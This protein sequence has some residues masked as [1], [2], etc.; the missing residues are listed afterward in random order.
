MTAALV[1]LGIGSG[2]VFAPAAAQSVVVQVVDSAGMAIPFALV[3]VNAVNGRVA[4]SAGMLRL[5]N[6]RGDTLRIHA[7]RIGYAPFNGRVG[8]SANDGVFRVVLARMTRELEAA[9]VTAERSTPLARNGFYDRMQRVQKGAIVGEF[10]TPEELDQRKPMQISHVLQGRRY[11]HVQREGMRGR[12][13]VGGRGQCPM[14][15]LLDGH[16]MNNVLAPNQG[17]NEGRRMGGG[18]QG[19]DLT[20]SIDE[21]VEGGS[22][23]AVE[24]YPSTANAPAELIPLTGGGSCGI[25]ALWTGGRH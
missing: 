14:T 2:A 18:F 8:R 23:A 22:V 4:D 20:M 10:I 21:L 9:R 16:R 6:M 1:L 25:I 7:R 13:T 19:G 3:D 5:A 24:I 17:R 11:V 15:I 12:A